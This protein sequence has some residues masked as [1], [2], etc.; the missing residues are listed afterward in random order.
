VWLRLLGR[1]LA[2]PK[3]A[4]CGMPLG[5]LARVDEGGRCFCLRHG[6]TPLCAECGRIGARMTPD[7]IR[8]CDR[9]ERLG[10]RAE[11]HARAILLQV[12][13]DLQALG[14]RCPAAPIPVRLFHARELDPGGPAAAA[15]EGRLAYRRR[16]DGV[17][18][19]LGMAIQRGLPPVSCGRIMAHELGHAWLLERNYRDLPPFKA[20]GLCELC[21]W[22]WITGRKRPNAAFKAGCMMRNQDPVYGGGFRAALKA[23]RAGGAQ[24]L[25]AWLEGA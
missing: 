21:A 3:C 8:L 12:R 24:A 14:F 5:L 17:T 6:R 10:V 22:F 23:Y 25:S 19:F 11:S 15:C 9:C 7:G 1:A 20:E 13:Q 4:L 2:R 16:D 18:E